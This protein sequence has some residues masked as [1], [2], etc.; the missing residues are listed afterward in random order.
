M[1]D[2]PIQPAAT[3]ILVRDSADGLETL[4]LRRSESLV[5]HGG[6]WV[7]PGGRID[8]ADYQGAPV[9]DDPADP[10][11]EPAA[12]AAA[13]REAF[14]EA[15]VLLKPADLIAFAHWITPMGRPRRFSAWFYL[16]TAPEGIIRTDG[17]EIT[18]HMWVAPVQ[19]LR[20]Q[21]AGEIML[22]GPTLASLLR[23]ETCSSAA[24][25]VLEASH[26]DYTEAGPRS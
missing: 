8:L 16:A 20:L 11:H 1:V 2:V 6:A 9:P 15:A 7:F 5:F 14:E 3:V 26:G 4:L 21:A 18:D 13:A 19:A 22:P 10:G 24:E 23:L 25:A 12:R 17:G